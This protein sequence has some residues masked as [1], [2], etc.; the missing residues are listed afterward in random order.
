MKLGVLKNK[1]CPL[2]NFLSPDPQIST[3][4]CSISIK[5]ICRWSSKMGSPISHL[6]GS[7]SWEVVRDRQ[8]DPAELGQYHE[9]WEGKNLKGQD[10]VVLGRHWTVEIGPHLTV[11]LEIMVLNKCLIMITQRSPR[12]GAG[13]ALSDLQPALRSVPGERREGAHYCPGAPRK[14]NIISINI[15]PRG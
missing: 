5:W 3:W 12:A 1:I 14:A 2:F 6:P 13:L 7:G 9:R 10:N 4:K 11:F 8:Q 15:R